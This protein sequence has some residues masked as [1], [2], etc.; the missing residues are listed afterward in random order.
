ML[1]S[2]QH[3]RA[4]PESLRGGRSHR[5]HDKRLRKMCVM[6]RDTPAADGE[7][8][9]RM[10]MKQ[11]VIADPYRLE[12]HLLAFT[13]EIAGIRGA[14]IDTFVDHRNADFHG[15]TSRDQSPPILARLSRIRQ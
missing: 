2:E 9:G 4:D 11:H 1:G 13:R 14:V 12:S 8:G 10:S 7:F 3:R 15:E 6:V 5:E